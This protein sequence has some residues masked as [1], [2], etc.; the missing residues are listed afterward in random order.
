MFTI[1]KEAAEFSIDVTAISGDPDLYVS[2]AS[3]PNSSN[4]LFVFV[5]RRELKRL[6]P[7]RLALILLKEQLLK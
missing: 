7:A 3:R 6:V 4:Q 1:N 5:R 2:M